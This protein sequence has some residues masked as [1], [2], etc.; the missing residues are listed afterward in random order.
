M[1]TAT[2]TSASLRLREG[3]II[4]D[5]NVLQMRSARSIRRVARLLCARIEPLGQGLWQMV[6][7]NA[8]AQ[9]KAVHGKKPE[10][11]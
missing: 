3:R 2:I 1:Y 5:R 8:C 9:V 4:V 6:R 11:A 10:E 7:D